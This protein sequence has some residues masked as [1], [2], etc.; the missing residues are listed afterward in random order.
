[1]ATADA[2][3][4]R[5]YHY[6]IL[7]YRRT[8]RGTVVISIANPLLFLV[9]V[10]LG[11]GRLVGPDPAALGGVDYLAFFAPGMLAAA[12]MQNGIIES[13]FPVAFNRGPG[14]AYPVA[15]GTPLEPEDI[16]HGHLL[17]MASRVTLSAAVF[18]A[19]MVAFGAAQSPLVLLAVPAAALTAM[20]FALPAAAWAVTLPDIRPVNGIFKWVVMPL[21]LFS[22]TFFAVS[23]LPEAVRPLVYATPLWH[24]VD[25]CRSLS[26]GTVSWPLAIVHIGY[27]AALGAV[28]Y[29]LARRTYRRHLHA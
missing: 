13:A 17:F 14:G 18:A 11:I 24:G 7:R 27:L 25:L 16:L 20:A 10:G 19:V 8:W 6:W 3:V 29:L 23:Q 1:M 28:G 22:G 12:A 15:A 26:L 21:Y 2:M 9:A 5:A 4:F